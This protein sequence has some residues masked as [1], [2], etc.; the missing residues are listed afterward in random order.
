MAASERKDDAKNT[1][2]T[3]RCR[4]RNAQFDG[5]APRLSWRSVGK[6]RTISRLLQLGAQLLGRLHRGEGAV[7]AG[8]IGQV[9]LRGRHF[10]SGE[11]KLARRAAVGRERALKAE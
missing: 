7:Q 11:L 2:A 5:I 9:H 1:K 8:E 3:P 10:L 6:A 4:G